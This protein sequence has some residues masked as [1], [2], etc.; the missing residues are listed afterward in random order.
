MEM[1]GLVEAGGWGTLGGSRV[2]LQ[3]NQRSGMELPSSSLFCFT[4]YESVMWLMARDDFQ[5][6]VYP[7]GRN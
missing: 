4:S 6:L 2:G 7:Q 1:P 3:T 5:S